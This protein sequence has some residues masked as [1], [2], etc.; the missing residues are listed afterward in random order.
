MI[1]AHCEAEILELSLTPFPSDGTLQHFTLSNA[2]VFYSVPRQTILLVDVETPAQQR[3]NK[4]SAE[5]SISL[6]PIFQ[7]VQRQII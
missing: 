7:S 6:L 5:L 4:L 1:F 3:G 2:T